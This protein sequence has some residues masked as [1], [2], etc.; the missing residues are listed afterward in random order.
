MPPPELFQYLEQVHGTP[1]DA[2]VNGDAAPYIS[3]S[4][5]EALNSA[6]L[7]IFEPSQAYCVADHPTFKWDCLVGKSTLV[8]L[9]IR[10]SWFG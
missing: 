1:I 6:G 5:R 4:H 10:G 2:F 3:N 7:Q 8:L 9:P